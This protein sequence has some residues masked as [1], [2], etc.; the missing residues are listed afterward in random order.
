MRRSTTDALVVAELCRK[1][2]LRRQP[3]MIPLSSCSKAW[4]K[5]SNSYDAILL[6]VRK[7]SIL[8]LMK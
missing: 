5:M 2:N 8:F 4:R 6:K 3:A 1:E 7:V